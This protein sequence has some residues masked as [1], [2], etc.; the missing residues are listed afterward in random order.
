MLHKIKHWLGLEKCELLE[1]QHRPH[2]CDHNIERGCCDW[3][4]VLKC[5]ECGEI[6]VLAS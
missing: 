1:I 5:K 6:I 3:T 2:C 4:A